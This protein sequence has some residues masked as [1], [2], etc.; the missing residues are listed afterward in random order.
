MNSFYK[1]YLTKVVNYDLLNKFYFKNPSD[2]P[3]LRNVVLKFDFKTYDYNLLIK[4]L[5]TL[6]L[7]TG[8]KCVI[9]KSKKPSTVLKIKKGIPV[10]CII[11]LKNSKAINFLLFLI[12]NKKLTDNN[13]KVTFNSKGYSAN[14]TITNVLSLGELQENYNFLKNI[15]NLNVKFVTTAKNYGEFKYLLNSYKF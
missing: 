6:E 9:I 14:I 2:L 1:E 5:M 4:C 3:S 12:N 13:Y 11:N 7:L 10:G 15:A 8:G